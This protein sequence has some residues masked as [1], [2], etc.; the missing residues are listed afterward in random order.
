M[1]KFKLSIYICVSIIIG[2]GASIPF[3]AEGAEIILKSIGGKP[4]VIDKVI[5][6]GPGD[7]LRIPQGT[8][9]EVRP[10]AGIYSRGLVFVGLDAPT[11]TSTAKNKTISIISSSTSPFIEANGG[12]VI[13]LNVSFKG[14]IFATGYGS[15][16]IAISTSTL[17]DSSASQVNSLRPF[18]SIFNNSKLDL[19]Y[20]TVVSK[21]SVGGTANSNQGLKNYLFEIYMT[22]HATVTATRIYSDISNE[23]LGVYNN[24]EIN[25]ENTDILSCR[26]W[27]SLFNNSIARGDL[28]LPVCEGSAPNIFNDSNSTIIYRGEKC[29]SSVLLIPGLQGSRLYRK[30]SYENKLWEPNIDADVQ[31]L[32]MDSAGKSIVKGIYT[33]DILDRVEILGFGIS[34]FSYYY[35]FLKFLKTLKDD[36][37]I[38]NYQTYPYDWRMSPQDIASDSLINKIEEMSL[39]SLNGRV[40]IVAHSY[41]GLVTKVLLK[42]LT[43]IDRE[44]LIDK[45]VLVAVPE[46]G[47][48]AALFTPLHG[49][50]QSIAWGLVQKATTGMALAINMPS[51]YALLPSAAFAKAV[52][53]TMKTQF[54]ASMSSYTLPLPASIQSAINWIQ[55][56]TGTVGNTSLSSKSIL[57][58]KSGNLLLE[59]T[60]QSGQNI[61]RQTDPILLAAYKIWSFAGIGVQ[62][63]GGMNYE[64]Q[65]CRTLACRGKGTLTGKPVYSQDGDGAVILDSSQNRLGTLLKVDLAKLNKVKKINIAHANI[66]ES[67]DVQDAIK[68]ILINGEPMTSPGGYIYRDDIGTEQ[69]PLY[70]INV[71]G[72]VTGGITYLSGGQKYETKILKQDNKYVTIQDV[73]N[74][75]IIKMGN[76]TNVTSQVKPDTISFISDQNQ[77]IDITTSVLTNGSS[78]NWT[79]G[80]SVGGGAS[81]AP[82][83]AFQ[84][85]PVGG[86]SIIEV[87]TASSTVTVDIDADGD[88]DREY[89]ASTGTS[90][91]QTI[92]ASSSVQIM[93]FDLAQLIQKTDELVLENNQIQIFALRS[94]YGKKLLKSKSIFV[95]SFAT[96]KKY[97]GADGGIENSFGNTIIAKESE[98]IFQ[99]LL[100]YDKAIDRIQEQ[101]YL[102]RTQI[103]NIN[104]YIQERGARGVG[105]KT[106]AKKL[107]AQNQLRDLGLI[108]VTLSEIADAE[109]EFL[110]LHGSISLERLQRP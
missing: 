34:K 10:G 76:T 57:V 58:Q 1:N 43:E 93:M 94:T 90:T 83:E 109:L 46:T 60:L 12:H 62:T 65:N 70:S 86:G 9:I 40:T 96:F 4:V 29:C 45:V 22:S 68:S 80:G 28:N 35:S 66:L 6:V 91:D 69:S 75:A 11:T 73:P 79:G 31:K 89:P 26:R 17:I 72:E 27:L 47:T 23:V 82:V 38:A 61:I 14:A 52:T 18:I 106:I 16:D 56:L 30:I 53:L 97:F 81:P 33:R 2:I 51:I 20:S 55:T 88:P 67:A 104:D 63:I 19:S 48:P 36:S 7:T 107:N 25:F 15:T 39:T 8:K 41:G 44:H 54:Q 102:Y 105:R 5:N 84:N 98:K 87:N 24:S 74:S 77:R 95:Q 99:D 3:Y 21:R 101:E 49:E 37:F 103:T 32:F 42:K 92:A 85:I 71:D 59:S 108:Y 100:A 50:N 64:Y 13:A 110:L 78:G